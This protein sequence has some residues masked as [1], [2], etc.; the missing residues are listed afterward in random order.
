MYPLWSWTVYVLWL[1]L[2]AVLLEKRAAEACKLT[3]RHLPAQL[4][5]GLVLFA[6]PALVLAV[7]NL[8]LTGRFVPF[9]FLTLPGSRA[10]AFL[11]FQLLV[12]VTE[13][14]FFRGW[15]QSGLAKH[16]PRWAAVC[17]TAA[18][19]S[20]LHLTGGLQATNLLL[21]LA[22]GLLFGFAK[23]RF[24]DCTVPALVLAHLLYDLAVV[25]V[26]I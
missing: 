25:N 10:V 12:A 19:F 20:L 24:R 6:L 8:S 11:L 7:I 18:V 3:R 21:P 15:M 4:I 17:V 14:C 2:T 22:I 16:L 26:T 13:E 23:E 1:C 5:W 9:Q